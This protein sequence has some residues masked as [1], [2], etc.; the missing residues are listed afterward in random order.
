MSNLKFNEVWENEPM[1]Q[2]LRYLCDL[3]QDHI[4]LLEDK[5]KELENLLALQKD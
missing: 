4:E 1:V 5:I 2:E 3:K